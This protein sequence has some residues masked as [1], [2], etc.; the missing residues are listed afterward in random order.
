MGP[1]T[2]FDGRGH[3]ASRPA[4]GRVSAARERPLGGTNRSQHREEAQ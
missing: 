3:P 1:V 4:R 2:A